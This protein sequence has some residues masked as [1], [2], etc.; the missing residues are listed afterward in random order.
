MELGDRIKNRRLELG[1]TLEE[2]GKMVGVGKSTVMK[3]ET[4]YIEN[5]K[6]DKIA[7][8]AKALK[9]SPLWIMGLDESDNIALVQTKKVPLLGEI[10]AGEPILATEDFKT[11]VEIDDA[12]HVDFCLKVKGD[13]MIDARINDGDI[14][15][16]R[17]QPEVENGE[18]AAVLIDNEAT[19]KRF[20]KNNGGVI[21][22]PENSKYQPKYYT[23]KDFKDIR[24]LGKAVFFQSEVR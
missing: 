10:A 5:M 13:S 3:W 24:I 11:Y 1:L 2:V 17:K 18:I 22:K 4:G 16:I 7:L 23:E 6:R 9:V 12:L 20:Y 19:L 8:L 14:V 21:L 15:F